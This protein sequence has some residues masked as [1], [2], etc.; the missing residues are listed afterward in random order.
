MQQDWIE[1]ERLDGGN[2]CVRLSNVEFFESRNDFTSG[3]HKGKPYVILCI[4]D[5]S[6]S[7][8]NIYLSEPY[9]QVKQK[10]M[11]AE[12][13]DLNDVVV[14]R[15]TK[16]EYEFIRQTMNFVAGALDERMSAKVLD[17][18]NEILEEEK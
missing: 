1:F 17:K 7:G 9:E 4:N 2:I 13:V 18:L 16:E 12:K 8:E 15:F 11:N 10:I 3:E 5:G 6:D 14:E